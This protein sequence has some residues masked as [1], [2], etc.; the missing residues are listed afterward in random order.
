MNEELIECIREIWESAR[1]QAVRSVN[2]VH[3]CANW[4]IGQQIVEAEQGGAERADYGTQLLKSLSVQLTN[5]YGSGFSLSALKYMRAFYL[6]YPTL[7]QIGHAARDQLA[8]KGTEVESPPQQALVTILAQTSTDAWQPGQLHPGLSW[9]HY[10]ALLKVAHQAARNFYEIEAVKNGWSTRQLERQINSLLFE[11]L[12]KSRDQ[13]GVLALAT[14]GLTPQQPV[15]IIKDPYVLEFLDLP[16]AHRLVE[17]QLEEALLTQLQAF[18][19]ELGS[20]FAF[21]GRQVRLTLE[22]DHFYPDLI[23][24]HIKLKCYVIIDLKVA[25]LNHA[26]LGQ[27][28]L[29]VHYYDREIA[30]PSDNPTI[31]LILCTDKNDAMVR[32][33]LDEKNQQIFASRYQFHLPSEEE[34]RAEIKRELELLEGTEQS[35]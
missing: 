12:L 25:K 33:V 3:V 16:E 19:L 10:R 6:S 9:T 1:T 31:G 34:L 23:F 26:D 18:L 7:I 30:E 28:Q 14:E 21:V 11:R 5:E 8:N 29:Y 27:M 24:Y 35:E 22:G 32:Y 4:L 17:S 2:S 20:G 13:A 15:D